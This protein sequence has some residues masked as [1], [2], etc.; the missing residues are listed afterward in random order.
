MIM[1]D[2]ARTLRWLAAAR[3]AE[4]E[5]VVPAAAPKRMRTLAVTSGKG[6]VGKSNVAVNVALEMAALGQRVS[7]LDADLALAN[8]DVL[9]GLN[10][11]YHLGHV[12]QG[13][14]TLREVVIEVTERLWLIPGGSGVEELANLSRQQ[15]TRL[16]A[17][18]QAFESEADCMIIDTAAGLA[19]NVTGVLRAADEVIIVTTPDP[20]ALV[21]S[22]AVIKVV[23]QQAPTKPIWVVV[24]NVVGVG[25]AERIFAQLQMAATRFLDRRLKL[26]GTIPRDAE[27]VEAV[28]EQ[29]PVVQYAPSTPAS[30]AF[31]LIAKQLDHPLVTAV[32]GSQ[33]QQGPLSFWST[34]VAAKGLGSH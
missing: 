5:P 11:Q 26:L 28:R 1:T 3:G 25:D 18:L 8:A 14:R 13:Q 20:T 7:L 30:R 22:Y 21:D 34:L 6:G 17:D 24:N 23:H 29:V 31:R 33:L 9:L 19:G 16:I 15:H 2:Q 27:L 32:P 10:P 4:T 12:L